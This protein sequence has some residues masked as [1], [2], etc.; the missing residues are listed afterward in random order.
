MIRRRLI[1]YPM[2]VCCIVLGM[3]QCLSIK[4][5]D[6]GVTIAATADD[7]L[8]KRLRHQVEKLT[9]GFGPRTFTDTDNLKN[10]ADYLETQFTKSGCLVSRQMVT[11]ELRTYQNVIATLPGKTPAK[12]IIGA[13][14]DTCGITPGAD[15]NT[16]GVAGLLELASLLSKESLNHTIEFVAYFNEEPPYFATEQMGS[17]YHARLVKSRNDD[18]K[19]MICLEMIGYY[20]DEPDSQ[21]YPVALMRWTLPSTGNFVGVVGDWGSWSLART[22]QQGMNKNSS[23]PVVRANLPG[24]LGISLD[25]SDH[26]NYWKLGYP[27][28][29]IT[30][31]SFYRNPHYHEKTDTPDTLDYKRMGDVV[32]ALSKAIL[33]LDKS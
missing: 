27:A 17:A 15:D 30:D 18:V 31:T 25:Y 22:I 19:G 28:V 13:H 11:L 29:M 21:Q 16:S 6:K 1:G 4:N 5:P 8:S 26:R 7:A 24:S 32:K 10:V 12:I 23:L 20:S 3:C 2:V 9:T 14:Y 33:E